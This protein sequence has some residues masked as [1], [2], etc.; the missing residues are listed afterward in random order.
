M[1]PFPALSP[2]SIADFEGCPKRWYLTKIEKKYK[3]VETEAITYGNDVHAKLES[4]VKFK[5][6]L[7]E[8][9]EYVAPVIDELRDGG[10]TLA[11]ELELI[12]TKDWDPIDDWW[13]RTGKVFL[14]GKVDLVAVNDKHAIIL[15]WK[16]GKPKPDP[17]QLNIYGA[18]LMHLF[19][20]DRV[21]VGFAWLKDKSSNTYTIT[22]ENFPEIVTDIMQRTDKMKGMYDANDFPARTTPLCCWCP[23]INDCE[24]AVYYKQNTSRYRKS[25]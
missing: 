10:Y 16:T 3:F 1:K 2:S 18:I 6:P 12:I 25:G 4:Y 24:E 17:F 7:P 14:R 20:L 22:A 21:D 9:L 11:A 13:N 23:A 15:D 19:S 5:T 8:H